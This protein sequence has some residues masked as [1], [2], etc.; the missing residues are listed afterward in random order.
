MEWKNEEER[1]RTAGEDFLLKKK[2]LPRAPSQRKHLQGDIIRQ[3]GANPAEQ[4]RD[5]L[6][7]LEPFGKGGGY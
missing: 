1:G 5:L 7:A 2:V 6:L 3:P 4:R